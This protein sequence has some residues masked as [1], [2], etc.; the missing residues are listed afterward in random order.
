MADG[1]KPMPQEY[2]RL[3]L[4]QPITLSN[5]S[6]SEEIVIFRPTCRAMTEVLDT[7]RL[8]VQ[9]ERFVEA[10]CRAVNGAADPL[11]FAGAEL[12]SIDGSELASVI[13]A[14]SQDADAIVVEENGDGITQPIIYTLQSPVRLNPVDG[15][16]V[17]QFEFI[18][19]K[20]SEITEYLDARG[21]TREFHTFMRTFGKPLG[22]RI[23]V[24]T[25]ALINALDFLDYL[26]IRRQIV[27]KFVTSRNRWKKASLLAPSTTIGRPAPGIH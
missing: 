8:N 17:A 12:N 21:E 16:T 22:I 9:I 4:L 6:E 5:G 10:C 27:P 23:P 13:T 26:V 19:R 3:K 20:V 24:M 2:G 7:A 25:D 1:E 14:M 18:A 11:P 15:E